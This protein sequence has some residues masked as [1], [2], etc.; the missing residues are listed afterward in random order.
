MGRP[1]KNQ[2]YKRIE[3]KQPLILAS[4]CVQTQEVFQN[5]LPTPLV[6]E[7]SVILSR[8]CSYFGEKTTKIITQ[9]LQHLKFPIA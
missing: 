5:N 9:P 4:R 3:L 6:N 1:S 7:G 2:I 8:A